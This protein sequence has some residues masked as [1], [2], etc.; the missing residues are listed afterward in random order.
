MTGIYCIRNA[1]DGSLYI[2]SAARS[3]PD[4][5]SRHRMDLRRNKHANPHLQAAWNFYKESSF[6]FS[7]LETCAP[8]RCIEREQYFIDILHPQYN[9]CRVAGSTFGHIPSAATRA[10]M[11]TANLGHICPPGTR[12]AISTAQRG[13]R[14]WLGRH[15]TEATKAK[16]GL[17][18]KGKVV[19]GETRARISAA[20]IKR[21]QSSEAR[22]K[23]R[24][25]HLGQKPSPENLL[26]LRAA[27]LGNKYF[28]GRKHT[29][30]A[31]SKM[32]AASKAWWQ[33]HRASIQPQ[34]A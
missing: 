1:I 19:S 23:L 32:S 34:A 3:F 20:G 12:A 16:I 26:K 14:H 13:N 33:N 28:L 7:V 15:H 31:R 6:Q 4:R 25:A 18:H 8:E 2:G 24:I 30:E 5:W 27:N 21:F 10:K 17:T 22:A 29:P 11:S 9:I